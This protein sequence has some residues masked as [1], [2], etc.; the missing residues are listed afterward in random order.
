M[1]NAFG[2]EPIST[3][4]GVR[5]KKKGALPSEPITATRLEVIPEFERIKE[6]AAFGTDRGPELQK[7]PRSFG[8]DEVKWEK[9]VRG[10]L[11]NNEQMYQRWRRSGQ[12]LSSYLGG[13]H[14]GVAGLQYGLDPDVAYNAPK[15]DPWLGKLREYRM[16][17]EQNRDTLGFREYWVR[18]A[19]LGYSPEFYRELGEKI[20]TMFAPT[21]RFPQRGAGGELFV[22]GETVAPSR[23]D[24]LAQLTPEEAYV[25][26]LTEEAPQG[27]TSIPKGLSIRGVADDLFAGLISRPEMKF[28]TELSELRAKTA[29]EWFKETYPSI[30]G[31]RGGARPLAKGWRD[32]FTGSRRFAP[33]IKTLTF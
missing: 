30:A 12:D 15:L 32:I 10:V 33:K 11:A 22:E 4:G 3:L 23:E 29:D 21:F 8:G 26:G 14:Y 24:I 25:F 7:A 20:D 6:E 13:T 27:Y 16:F 9:Y 5:K 17:N 2:R 31:E 19:Q 18:G 28:G 1:T